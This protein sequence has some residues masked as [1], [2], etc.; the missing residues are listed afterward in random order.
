MNSLKLFQNEATGVVTVTENSQYNK[1]RAE[2]I[3]VLAHVTA[4][5]YGEVVDV[6]LHEGAVFNFHGKIKGSVENLGGVYHVF[7]L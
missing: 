3:I 4:R 2:K 6:V 5:A 1:L 7:P